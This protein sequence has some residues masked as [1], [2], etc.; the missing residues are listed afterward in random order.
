MLWLCRKQTRNWI[1]RQFAARHGT[2]P[3]IG[4]S[5]DTSLE[6]HPRPVAYCQPP[7][8]RIEIGVVKTLKPGNNG[9]RRLIEIYGDDPAAVRYRLNPQQQISYTTSN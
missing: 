3:C 1:N 9:T 4:N 8:N 7:P 5:H 2:T 6:P